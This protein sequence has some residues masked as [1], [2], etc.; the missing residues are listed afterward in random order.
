MTGALALASSIALGWSGSRDLKTIGHVRL[1]YQRVFQASVSV[2]GV[3]AIGFYVFRGT[4]IQSDLPQGYILIMLPFGLVALLL[5]RVMRRKRLNHRGDTSHC[6]S[7]TRVIGNRKH[8]RRFVAGVVSSSRSPLTDGW[9][10]C[11]KGCASP[12]Y[13]PKGRRDRWRSNPEFTRSRGPGGSRLWRGK[14]VATTSLT[15]L[16]PSMVRRLSWDLENADAEPS[17]VPP[18]TT[19]AGPRVKIRPIAGPSLI[20]VNRPRYRSANR[21]LR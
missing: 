8:R 2:F 11:R 18:L 7:Q 1:E 17:L 16:R 14:L 15:I 10:T 3:V 5:S 13:V 19:I 12:C 21:I 9:R 6:A 20:D 4:L